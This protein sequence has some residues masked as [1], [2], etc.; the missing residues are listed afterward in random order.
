MI[1]DSKLFYC[2]R[3]LIPQLRVTYT[4]YIINTFIIHDKN[5]KKYGQLEKLLL[6]HI[7]IVYM[8]SKTL[9]NIIL[10]IINNK[11]TD[12]RTIKTYY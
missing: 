4:S 7:N 11:T 9:P 6:K 8:L 12:F 2:N 1:I 5:K 10:S 3:L